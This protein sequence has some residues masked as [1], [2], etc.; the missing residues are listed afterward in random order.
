[1]GHNEA[2]CLTT[3]FL[4]PWWKRVCPMLGVPFWLQLSHNQK[5]LKPETKLGEKP[6][7]ARSPEAEDVVR[8]LGSG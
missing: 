5:E 6:N 8:D 3:D 1:M 2:H 4:S 7:I